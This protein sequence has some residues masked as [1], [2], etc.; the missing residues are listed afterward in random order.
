[1]LVRFPTNRIVKLNASNSIRAIQVLN[2]LNVVLF[3]NFKIYN[4]NIAILI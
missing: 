2:I 3:E 4:I 1:M